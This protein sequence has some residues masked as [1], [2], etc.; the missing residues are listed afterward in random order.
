MSI[1]ILIECKKKYYFVL[2]LVKNMMVICLWLGMWSSLFINLDKLIL[3]YLLKN[4]IVF[5]VVEMKVVCVL[6]Y[7]KIFVWD[8]KCYL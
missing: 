7:C 6:I 4:I 1:K 3:V 5:L 8:R 2:K